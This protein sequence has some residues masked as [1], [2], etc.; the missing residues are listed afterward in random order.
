MNKLRFLSLNLFRDSRVTG[1]LTLFFSLVGLAMILLNQLTPDSWVMDF[2]QKCIQTDLQEQIALLETPNPNEKV[3]RFEYTPKGKLVRWYSN[4]YVPS[5][6]ITNQILFADTQAIVSDK[7]AILY[8]KIIRRDSILELRLLPI[9]LSYPLENEYV[10]NYV[11]L[12]RFESYPEIVKQTKPDQVSLT[13]IVVSLK[14]RDS[15]GKFLYSFLLNDTEPYRKIWLWWAFISFCISCVL[16]TIFILHFLEERIS[17]PII[18]V[19]AEI[20]FFLLIRFALLYFR[21][22]NQ[23]LKLIIFS[24]ETLAINALNPS[25]GDLT[26]NSILIFYITIRLYFKIKPEIILKRIQKPNF[27]YLFFFGFSSLSWFLC[28]AFFQFFSLIVVNSQIYFEFSDLFKLDIFSWIIFLNVWLIL[29]VLSLIIYFFSGVSLNY[30]IQ[31]S[32]NIKKIAFI[33]LIIFL[34]LSV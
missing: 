30:I 31:N 6:T 11:F 32:L 15:Q 16:G 7:N 25:L 14:I 4:Q 19:F 2:V 21:L 3:L 18:R 29:A 24:S 23:I 22:P 10:Q 26:L 9:V 8:K 28:Y 5:E 17:N 1:I 27:F 13:P 20:G 12:G 34:V 33:W